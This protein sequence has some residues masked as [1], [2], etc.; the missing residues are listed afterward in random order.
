MR[1][2][3]LLVQNNRPEFQK[4]FTDKKLPNDSIERLQRYTT[5]FQKISDDYQLHYN[6]NLNFAE[7][8][9]PKS[10]SRIFAAS[11]FIFQCIQNYCI[12][13]DPAVLKVYTYIY[14]RYRGIIKRFVNDLNSDFYVLKSNLLSFLIT[15]SDSKEEKVAQYLTTN[16]EVNN[17]IKIMCNC[18]QLLSKYPNEIINKNNEDIQ[19]K[20]IFDF[21]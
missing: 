14:D 10:K 21:N 5:M 15:M 12:N 7:G 20:E 4:L 13:Y 11:S 6:Y 17:F 9:A 8:I 3:L 1:F 18:L 19:P 16:F 2:Q